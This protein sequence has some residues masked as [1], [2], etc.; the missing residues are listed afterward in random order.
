MKEVWDWANDDGIH[1]LCHILY[2]P[3]VSSLSVGM[4]YKRQS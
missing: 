2:L 3:E 4:D 1:W